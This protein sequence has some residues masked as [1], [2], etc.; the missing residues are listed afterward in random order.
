MRRLSLL[1][2]LLMLERVLHAGATLCISHGI[3]EYL[4][5][6]ARRH[7]VKEALPQDLQ[8]DSTTRPAEDLNW[9]RR[10]TPSVQDDSLCSS[11]DGPFCSLLGTDTEVPVFADGARFQTG[12][13]DVFMTM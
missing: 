9:V 5:L 10:Y 4:V 7:T 1:T 11:T 3:L 8:T 6:E 12:K 13:Y 2:L